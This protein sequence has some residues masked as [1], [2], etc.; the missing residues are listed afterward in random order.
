ML[1]I[2]SSLPVSRKAEGKKSARRWYHSPSSFPAKVLSFSR[3]SPVEDRQGYG[4][5]PF[6]PKEEECC[7]QSQDKAQQQVILAHK[8]A[9]CHIVPYHISMFH[10]AVLPDVCLP[11][12]DMSI[13]VVRHRR[14]G[15]YEVRHTAFASIASNIFQKAIPLSAAMFC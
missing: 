13:I 12:V 6:L 11:E 7:H 8:H 5:A 2:I 3:S 10:R 4:L 15:V 9:S 14:F 1:S